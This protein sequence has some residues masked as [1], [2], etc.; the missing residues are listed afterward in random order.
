MRRVAVQNRGTSTKIIRLTRDVKS[1]HL[2]LI[3][4]DRLPRFLAPSD[5][6]LTVYLKEMDRSI[7]RHR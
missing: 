6:T 2:E 7:N 3:P 5:D 1:L 4:P